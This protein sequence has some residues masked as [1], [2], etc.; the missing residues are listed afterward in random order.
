MHG[1][2]LNLEKFSPPY[3]DGT[4]CR[5]WNATVDR[6]SPPYGD[7]TKRF[8]NNKVVFVFSPPYGDGTYRILSDYDDI[9]VSVPLRG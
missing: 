9:L 1:S 5:E 6:F 4:F 2:W 7:G 8:T 3:G